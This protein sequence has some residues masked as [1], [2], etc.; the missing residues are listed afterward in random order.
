[1]IPVLIKITTVEK[2]YNKLRL[3]PYIFAFANSLR[4]KDYV[5]KRA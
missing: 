4:V 2:N 3:I 1:M 5:Q